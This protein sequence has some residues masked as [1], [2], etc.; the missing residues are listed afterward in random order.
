ML[1][2]VSFDSFEAIDQ[3]SSKAIGCLCW[4]LKVL[5]DMV[6]FTAICLS[7]IRESPQIS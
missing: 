6:Y 7:V 2:F 4:Q 1:F 5:A 3:G